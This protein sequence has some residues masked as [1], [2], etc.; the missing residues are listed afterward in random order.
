MGFKL[1]EKPR[2]VKVTK[3]LATQFANMETI[4]N[5]RPLSERRLMVYRKALEEGAFRPV[6]WSTCYCK[7]TKSV[8]RVNGKHT[9]TLLSSY[10]TIPDFY[11]T[12]E[13]YAADTL[14][15]V[16]ELYNTFDSKNQS[17]TTRDINVSFAA[18][19]PEL[20]DIPVSIISLIITGINYAELQERMYELQPPERAEKILDN[21]EF[22]VW[23][24]EQLYRDN[25][26]NFKPL[27]KAGVTAAM[28]LT[29]NKSRQA[30]TEFWLAVRDET[31]V[32]PNLPDR[33]LMKWISR[34]VA[35]NSSRKKVDASDRA[36]THE[37]MIKSLLAWNA[38]R[39]GGSTELRYFKDADMP[40]VV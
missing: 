34:S 31:G 13:R 27:A 15:E 7:E 10:P 11:V 9:S 6:T 20:R 33:K 17:R 18:V 38:W 24:H 23:L 14:K 39:K 5:D 37:F 2:T 28:F 22:A 36:T 29:F 3:S 30:A 21:I 16:V 40:K 19:A 4:P 35:L 26:S 32:S 12:I 8:Y 25:I 1:I